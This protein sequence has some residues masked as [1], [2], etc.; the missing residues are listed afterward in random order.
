MRKHTLF[1]CAL[2]AM[3]SCNQYDKKIASPYDSV[4]I[5][6][7]TVNWPYNDQTYGTDSFQL[8][9]AENADTIILN[10]VQKNGLKFT[11]DM[12]FGVAGSAYQYEGNR[13]AFSLAHPDGIGWSM[14][15]V[16][17]QKGSWLN[18]NLTKIADNFEWGE[19][20]DSRFGLLWIDYQTLARKTKQSYKCYQSI[21]LNKNTHQFSAND[22]PLDSETTSLN[23][24]SYSRL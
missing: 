3:T 6:T 15:E 14:W 10:Q 21:I 17:C 9:D 18:P 7:N 23:E 19:G 5:V 13:V 11:A 16:F 24:A 4:A 1:L 12:S 8:G 20:Y 22:C 2:L